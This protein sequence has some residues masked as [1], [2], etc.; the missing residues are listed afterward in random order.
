M[1]QHQCPI[2]YVQVRCPY[3]GRLAA[4]ATPSSQ[5]RVKCVRCKRLYDW[6]R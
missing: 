1:T 3:C 2:R 6:R 4:Q 5:L